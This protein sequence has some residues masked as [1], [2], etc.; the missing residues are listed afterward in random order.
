VGKFCPNVLPHL[1][2]KCSGFKTKQYIEIL[3]NARFVQMIGLNSG[4]DISP[5]SPPI[6]TGVQKPNLPNFNILVLIMTYNAT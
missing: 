4:Q 5:I 6:F 2:S 1:H 3:K